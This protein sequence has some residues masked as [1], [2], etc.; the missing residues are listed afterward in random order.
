MPYTLEQLPDR[1]RSVILQR[2]TKPKFLVRNF[3]MKAQEA[4]DMLAWEQG[5]DE[6]ASNVITHRA[7]VIAGLETK[8]QAL[9][10][11]SDECY[12][13]SKSGND[14]IESIALGFSFLYHK[15]RRI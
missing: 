8:A 1:S 14:K 11:L 10:A 7:R 13:A 3:E 9:K 4:W 2:E 6:I 12:E 15:A 5:T